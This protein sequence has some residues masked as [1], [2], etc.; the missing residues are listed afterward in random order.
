MR[1]PF[2]F[3]L[4]RRAAPNLMPPISSSGGGGWW[5]VIRESFTGAWQQNVEIRPDLVLAYHAVF[6][7][8]TLIA[9]DVGKLCMRLIQET[10]D[11]GIWEETASAAFSPFLKHPNHF[12]NPVQFRETWITS[13]LRSGNTYALKVR[14]QRGVVIAAYVL[15][16][17]RVKP[18]VSPDGLVF[19]ELT[20]DNIS[21]VEDTVVVPQSEIFHDR[22]NCLFH[23]LVGLSPIF[24]CGLAATQGLA[25]QN[26][27]TNFFQNMSRPGGI[28]IAPGPI[29][30]DK[31]RE[32]KILW[33]E[34]FGGANAGKTA[35]LGDGVKYQTIAM[36]AAEA[37][38]IDQL[39]WS[40]EVVCSCFHVP[41]FK[42]GFGPVPTYSAET[43]NQIYYSDCLQSL[44][45]Q[46]ENVVSYG[47]GLDEPKDGR[48]LWAELDLDDLIRMD[49]ATQV[50]VLADGVTGSIFTPNEAR[51]KAN[52]R[53]LTGGNTVYLQQQQFSIEALNERD[54]ADPFAKPST[55]APALPAP[56]AQATDEPP[57]DAARSLEF[58]GA[59]RSALVERVGA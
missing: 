18:L 20:Q 35:V 38:M 50:K 57:D 53:P 9:N 31:A 12:Q 6:A 46:Y 7:C 5:P 34:S 37:Q 28:L 44:I 49:S 30:P 54:Q 36:T 40:A 33:D 55:P 2:G 15:D 8:I 23:P 16:P 11:E 42:L 17:C 41:P 4:S 48:N 43:M 52:K 14:D 24:A 19:Y 29:K 39:K 25:A 26:N 51:K 10:A 22:M 13:K 3:Q 58:L 32:M 1:L 27:S 21:G 56:Q 59:L 45:E 47:L